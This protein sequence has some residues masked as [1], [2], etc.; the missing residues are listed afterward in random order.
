MSTAREAAPSGMRARYFNA[1]RLAAY[2]LVLYTLGHTL[3]AV[4]QT[5]H[6]G[7]ES[8]AVVAAMRSVP[9]VSQG[10]GC[11]WYGF[12]RGFGLLVS[13]Y[14]AVSCFMAWHLGGASDGDRG[15]LVPLGW[16][17]FVSHAAGLVL[18]CAYFFPA[19]M[20]FSGAITAL[21]GLGCIRATRRARIEARGSA[22]GRVHSS[23]AS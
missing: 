11:T 14:F 17:L 1:H 8:D 15:A 22:S 3:G 19:P 13:I 21:L 5:P 18:A 20:I 9:L 7:A 12:Y 6:F 2:L 16:A 10:A 23:I 4:V